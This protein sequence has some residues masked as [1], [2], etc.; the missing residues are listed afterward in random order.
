K[1]FYHK[2]MRF[3]FPMILILS[4]TISAA[5]AQSPQTVLVLDPLPTSVNRGDIVPITGKL[6]TATGQPIVGTTVNL[7][8][9]NDNKIYGSPSTDENGNFKFNW[10]VANTYNSY[11]WYALFQGDLVY[12]SST[13]QVY[14]VT[15]VPLEVNGKFNYYVHLEDLPS[16]AQINESEVINNAFSFWEHVYPNTNFYITNST[17]FDLDVQW[18]KDFG[19]INGYIGEEF[20]GHNIFVG[21]GDS[22][23]LGTWKP[24]SSQTVTHIATHEIGHFLGL[25]HVTDPNNVMY[26]YT[27]VQYGTIQIINYLAPSYY[28]Y[29][30]ICTN[31]NLTSYYFNATTNDPKYGFN[32]Y[33]LPSITEFDKYNASK[34]FSYY[35]N[36]GCSGNN[37]LSFSGICKGISRDGGLLI[38][39]PSSLSEGLAT[40]TVELEEQPSMTTTESPTTTSLLLQ[41]PIQN[42]TPSNPTSPNPNPLLN[43]SSSNQQVI[44][45]VPE[46]PFVILILSASI[47]LLIGF[48]R[49]RFR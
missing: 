7:V 27:Q 8:L 11:G 40:V 26:P 18:I 15:A 19:D 44:P 16:Y 33:F 38:A 48:Y 31:Q 35:S 47:G 37:T 1:S 4:I 14:Y 39:M 20:N 13:S 6:T 17:N 3:V 25:G 46:F 10:T 23:C 32:F 28:R 22:D 41:Q 5:Y 2:I 45:P 30:P 12:Q 21:L 9:E 34:S 29:V 43:Y 36:D 42:P 24:Y 49:I